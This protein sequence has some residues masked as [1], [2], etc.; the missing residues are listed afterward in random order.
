M[1]EYFPLCLTNLFTVFIEYRT[2][3]LPSIMGSGVVSLSILSDKWR[4]DY[5]KP[6]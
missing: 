5:S 1:K 4:P 3:F 6:C 2:E